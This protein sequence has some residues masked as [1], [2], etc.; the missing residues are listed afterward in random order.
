M[1]EQ[2][3]IEVTEEMLRKASAA[4]P[5]VRPLTVRIMVGVC[6]RGSSIG[7]ILKC[8]RE[9][10]N[11]SKEW[12]TQVTKRPLASRFCLMFSDPVLTTRC[13]GCSPATSKA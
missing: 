8:A 5:S 6:H 3:E 2:N 4:G 13:G 11:G 7:R 12:G 1:V 10:P 9:C